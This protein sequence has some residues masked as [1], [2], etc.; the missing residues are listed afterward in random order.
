MQDL[1]NC[2]ISRHGLAWRQSANVCVVAYVC[3]IM[4][5]VQ[6]GTTHH[7]SVHPSEKSPAVPSVHLPL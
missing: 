7:L 1:I 5:L 3:T 4:L 6:N 2:S